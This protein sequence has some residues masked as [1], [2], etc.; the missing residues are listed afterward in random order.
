MF[1]G[2]NRGGAETIMLDVFRNWRDASYEFIGIHRKDGAY[3]EAFYGAGPKLI[4]LAPKRLGFVRY[5]MQLRRL[6]K[7]EQIS[8]VHAQYWLDCL[9]ACIATVGLPIRVMNT[10]HGFFQKKGVWGRLCY[11]SAHMA[12]DVCFVSTNE[13]DWYEKEYGIH[14]DK[15]HVIYNGVDLRKIASQND[16]FSFE[17]CSLSFEKKGETRLCMVGS[18]SPA[19]N[20]L[21]IC[22]A[23]K[24]LDSDVEFYFIGAK[25]EQS[26]NVYQECYEYCVTN[27]ILDRVHF[28]GEQGDVYRWLKEMDGFV[29]ATK[30]DTFGIALVEAVA[31]GMPVVACDWVVTKEVCEP[32]E[33]PGV[34]LFSM[35]DENDCTQKIRYMI[36][37]IEECRDSAK[38]N[39][40]IARDV[41]SI[42]AYLK[43]LGEIY[44]RY[45]NI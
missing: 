45:D 44:S 40:Q 38:V 20:Q 32:F 26:S 36:S 37:H 22:K 14:P 9:Y 34:Q 2:M 16:D 39:A 43:R 12:D 30:H 11:L 10:Y 42:K 29:Y 8:I 35:H 15:C 3:K 7:K 17:I 27:K 21:L 4:Q 5:L 25:N 23:M 19:R 1:G 41:Y 24:Q 28:V 31:E 18:F 33:G 6:L 13:Q